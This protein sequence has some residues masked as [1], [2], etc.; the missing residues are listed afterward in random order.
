MKMKGILDTYNDYLVYKKTI[1]LLKYENG[2]F[3]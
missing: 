2:P 3:D 1:Y